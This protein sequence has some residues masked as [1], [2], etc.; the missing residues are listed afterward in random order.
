MFSLKATK[1][2]PDLTW[3]TIDD[4][5][6]KEKAKVTKAGSVTPITRNIGDIAFL[7]YTSGI[8]ETRISLLCPI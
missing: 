6:S 2:W 3:I 1:K 7:Q 4:I 5:L 8:Y